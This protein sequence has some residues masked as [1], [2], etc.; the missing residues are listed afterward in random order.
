[1]A[2]KSVFDTLCEKFSI[3]EN[4]LRRKIKAEQNSEQIFK[5]E[6]IDKKINK[7]GDITWLQ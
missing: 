4:D 6:K 1:M 3:S 5:M 2:K 7:E